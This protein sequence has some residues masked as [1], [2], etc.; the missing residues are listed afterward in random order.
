MRDV[1]RPLC[2]CVVS[3]PRTQKKKRSG[4]C[5]INVKQW[6]LTKYK[7]GRDTTKQLHSNLDSNIGSVVIRSIHNLWMATKGCESTGT[8]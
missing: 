3:T 5:V 7:T 6:G 2:L 1:A 4:Y 8:V